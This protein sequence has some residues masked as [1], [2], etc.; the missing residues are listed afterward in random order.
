[1][2][3][4][5]STMNDRFQRTANRDT[6]S[7]R[8]CILE[9]DGLRYNLT[10]WAKAHP[11]GIN[12]LHKFHN[13]DASKAFH[14]AAHSAHAYAMLKDFV[15]V[16][17]HNRDC[18]ETTMIQEEKTTA[19]TSSSSSSSSV[20]AAA[21]TPPI[22][23]KRPRWQQKLFT[24]ED[25]IG[26]HKYLGIFCLLH[27][28]FRFGQMYFGDISAGYG[29]RLGKGPSIWP[30]LCLLPHA[31]LSLS[32]LIF[33]TVPR[34][35]VVGKPMIWQEFR[36]HNIV[37]GIRSV[38]CAFLAW[39]SVYFNHQVPWRRIA[40]VGS[41]MTALAANIV[42]DEATKRLR[43]D[44]S[45]STTA[46]MPYWDGC[47]VE[48]QKRFKLFYAYCQFMATLACIAV[49]SPVWGLAVLLA[50]QGASLFMTLVR[51]GL[52][53]PKGYHIAYTIT[54]IMP[55]FVGFRCQSL[56]GPWTFPAMLVGGATLFQL[57]RQGINKYLLW[58]P[59]YAARILWGDRFIPY[60]VW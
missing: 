57:R 35:R 15:V 56:M 18:E 23:R 16:E 50:I 47:S 2:S 30:A 36:A 12:V 6:A 39:L 1:M 3:F 7:E 41:C 10:A 8:E 9:I 55:Y 31:L 53:S 37:F 49:C 44:S 52:L 25:P 20:A 45:E 42:A 46:T 21:T 4:S 32:S 29:T 48:T 33:H 13:K 24:K 43:S 58:L 22:T 11:G 26:V 14:A 59:L 27:Y 19:D 5:N 51:K 28:A 34:E 54:L 38:L 40:V 60:T 17:N